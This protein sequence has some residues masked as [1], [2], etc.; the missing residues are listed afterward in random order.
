V[1]QHARTA[2]TPGKSRAAPQLAGGPA[3]IS[4]S[5][6]DA[7]LRK[8]RQ[9]RGVTIAQ[10]METTGWQSHSVRGFLSA[11]VRKKLGLPL[12]SE[13]GKDGQRRY[14]IVDGDGSE[15]GDTHTNVTA[16]D[17]SSGRNSAHRDRSVGAHGT[18]D[19]GAAS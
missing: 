14:R 11:V 8:L 3:R 5:K 15:D 10:M 4:T 9:A 13:V 2:A 17:R 1:D 7:V 18:G 12:V 19:N 16:T 6:A